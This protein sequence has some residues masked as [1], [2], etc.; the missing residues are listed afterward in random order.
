MRELAVGAR[1]ASVSLTPR[2]FLIS[3]SR[4]LS[5]KPARAS[6]SF[7]VENSTATLR[8]VQKLVGSLRVLR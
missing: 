2:T 8:T 1:R 5:R 3:A 6:R 4:C 7:E